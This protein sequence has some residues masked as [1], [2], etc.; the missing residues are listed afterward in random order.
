MTAFQGFRKT[1]DDAMAAKRY[2]NSGF[3][4]NQTTAL[5]AQGAVIAQS[6]FLT[7]FRRCHRFARGES[8][9]AGDNDGHWTKGP[10]DGSRRCSKSARVYCTLGVSFDRMP[11]R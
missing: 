2:F 5:A 3:Y 10:I 7:R 6:F 11:L 4:R 1:T 8:D 9:E